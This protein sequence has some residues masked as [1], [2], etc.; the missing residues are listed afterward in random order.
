M[1]IHMVGEIPDGLPIIHVGWI[2]HA[3]D[4]PISNPSQ[5][6]CTY[7]SLS[8]LSPPPAL[9]RI[10]LSSKLQAC[11]FSAVHTPIPIQ[12]SVLFII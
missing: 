1:D 2:R 11:N 8:P 12:I 3:V 10:N 9:T 5:S 7:W 4:Q 6:N